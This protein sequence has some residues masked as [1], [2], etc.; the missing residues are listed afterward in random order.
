MSRDE[1]AA[2]VLAVLNNSKES[3]YDVQ[4][5]P[6]NNISVNAKADNTVSHSGT[7]LKSIKRIEKAS[8]RVGRL[9][10]LFLKKTALY[11]SGKPIG[12]NMFKQSD[13]EKNPIFL[14]IAYFPLMFP[15]P[16]ILNPRSHYSRYI[17]LCGAVLTAADLAVLLF[18]RFLCNILRTVFTNTVN[19][20]TSFEH[21]ALSYTGYR[22]ISLTET[23]GLFLIFIMFVY[24]AAMTIFGRMPN[25][26]SERLY[27]LSFPRNNKENDSGANG[28][29]DNSISVSRRGIGISDGDSF[30]DCGGRKN[31]GVRNNCAA[32]ENISERK[33]A[34]ASTGDDSAPIKVISSSIAEREA[35]KVGRAADSDEN[36]MVKI[37]GEPLE[38]S[39]TVNSGQNTSNISQNI[40]DVNLHTSA[41][42]QSVA[43]ANPDTVRENKKAG[44]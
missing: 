44:V 33:N 39:N 2:A 36:A 32:S 8:A 28:S 25:F 12:K 16:A 42:N 26:A 34:G 27:R 29:A 6:K 40:S 41:A 20:G 7:L 24:S 23:I 5:V 30:S 9:L 4:S 3:G 15:V 18:C 17:S 38:N 10:R 35:A 19:M 14:C 37:T 1:L 31:L 43:A 22:L 11:L 21:M 13:L